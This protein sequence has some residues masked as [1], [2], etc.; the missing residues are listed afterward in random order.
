LEEDDTF[1]FIAAHLA[2]QFKA[3]GTTNYVQIEV[4][5]EELGLLMLTIQRQRGCR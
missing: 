5:H 2:A 1:A 4:N 3:I